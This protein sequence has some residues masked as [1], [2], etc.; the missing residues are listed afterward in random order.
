MIFGFRV[1]FSA[2]LI[3]LFVMGLNTRTDIA[4]LPLHQLDFLVILQM[5]RDTD[6]ETIKHI[7]NGPKK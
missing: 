6:I 7:Q 1:G 2:E 3:D 4:R 5:N